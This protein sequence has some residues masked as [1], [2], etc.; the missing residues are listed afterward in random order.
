MQG[1]GLLKDKLKA[2]PMVRAFYM[3]DR[4][5]PAL[6]PIHDMWDCVD[7]V[8][9]DYCGGVR[10][11]KSTVIGVGPG[12]AFGQRMFALTGVPQGVLACAHGGTSMEQWDPKLKKLGS[13]SLYGAMMRRFRK[14][15]SRVAGLVWYQ[16]CIKQRRDEMVQS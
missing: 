12:V 9:I 4:W 15:G 3:N 16:G 10:P 14:N 13:K 5:A 11:E 7:Q 1:C 8:H 6:D 2:H